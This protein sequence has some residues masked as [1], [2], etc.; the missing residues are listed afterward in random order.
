MICHTSSRKR[1]CSENTGCFISIFG[2]CRSIAL[3]P[4]STNMAH[5]QFELSY[6]A[7]MGY[8][9]KDPL[10]PTIEILKFCRRF[11]LLPF[12]HLI[13]RKGLFI[14]TCVHNHIS[15]T[16]TAHCCALACYSLNTFVSIS[17][18]STLF[19]ANVGLLPTFCQSNSLRL[20]TIKESIRVTN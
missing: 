2:V 7:K 16:I 13:Q 6:G 14:L 5:M 12:V 15:T 1:P 8:K 18:P 20:L 11:E 3:E 9:V 10:H 4:S 19:S 17:Q